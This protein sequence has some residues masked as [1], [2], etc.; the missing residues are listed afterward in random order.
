MPTA[1]LPL[2]FDIESRTASTEKDSR[3]V[4]AMVEDDQIVKR[5]GLTSHVTA[6]SGQGRGIFSWDN[7]LIAVNENTV[8]HIESQ[9]VTAYAL[10]LTGTQ[11]PMS[12]VETGN[13]GWLAMH[14]GST[15]YAIDKDTN[16]LTAPVGGTGVLSATIDTPGG[17]Y[18]TPP[19]V[20]FTG[21]GATADALGTAVL[22]NHRVDRITI[23][24]QG[25]YTAGNVP[26]ITID[27]PPTGTTATVSCTYTQ[28][29]YVYPSSWYV[30]ASNFTVTNAGSGYLLGP[31]ATF[32][33]SNGIWFKKQL[34]INTAGSVSSINQGTIDSSIAVYAY[35][36]AADEYFNY[37][38][39]TYGTS[40][41]SLTGVVT[42]P[43]NT[44]AKATAVM[45]STITGPFAPGIVYLDGYV[46]V[47]QKQASISSTITFTA[48]ASDLV[49][50]TAHGIAANTPVKFTTTVGDTLPTL[51]A[52]GLL[53]QGTSYYVVNPT[54]N[55]FQIAPTVGGTAIDLSGTGSGTITCTA[56]PPMTSRVYGSDLEDP[57]HWN[58][59][60]FVSAGSD[61]DEGV[62]ITKHLNHI[63]VF[64]QWSTEF[65]YN[66]GTAAPASPLGVNYSSKL[67]I[68][69]ANGYSIAKA[70][71]TVFWIGNSHTNGRSV[72][73]LDGLQPRKI[74]NRYIDKYLNADS[75]VNSFA[76]RS[77]CFKV[78]G[79]TLYVLTL[80]DSNITFVFDLDSQKWY[81]WTSQTG[82]TNGY[83]GT[84]TYFKCTAYNGNT[85]YAP[86]IYLQA[87]HG[88]VIYKLDTAYTSDDGEHIYFR[89]VSSITDSGTTKRKFYRRVEL[90]GD[91][92][93]GTAYVRHSDD[94]YTTWSTRR[95][96]NLADRRPILYQLG[97]ARRRAWEVFSSSD[98]KIRLRAMELDFDI[99]E[100]GGGQE[101]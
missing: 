76:V 85:E 99:G 74:S 62:A 38:T 11:V 51:T 34:Q 2:T 17:W 63:V 84:E 26:T 65:F 43:P 22:F 40:I 92:A 7:K 54:T 32:T 36:T 24:S 42:A 79:H 83:D 23:D 50:W 3:I 33:L 1:R 14:N 47:L 16:S 41:S 73:L 82:D 35:P 67:E 31:T 13:D 81:Q 5:P 89:A 71:Q 12:F 93:G 91:K 97:E 60:N 6:G 56:Y 95:S 21:G 70:E 87:D 55:T 57:T 8:Y 39:A 98:V 100:Q 18:D 27:P 69:C 101:G 64:G 15:I 44:T 10:P 9:D 4:N 49:T 20:T 96:V 66:A 59:L 53:E 45:N 25:T 80:E 30:I 94:D 90:V 77:F 48:G 75:M 52:G 19:L 28:G 46:Y 88:G 86:A 68:G 78:A 37:S 61:P 72:Y 58:A 29:Y